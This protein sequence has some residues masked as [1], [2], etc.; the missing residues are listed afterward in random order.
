MYQFSTTQA[1]NVYKSILENPLHYAEVKAV[2]S[3]VEHD[4]SKIISG[5]ISGG[6][7]DTPGIGFCTSRELDIEFYPIGE[8]PRQAKIEIY[9]RITDGVN[10]SEWIPKG[11]YFVSR[12]EKNKVTGV[13]KITA[14]DSMLKAEDTFWRN[15]YKYWN[16]PASQQKVVD[17]IAYRMD[18]TVDIRTAYGST[19]V[20]FPVDEDG[21][22]TMREV[23]SSIAVSN[24]ANWV[25]T[26]KG[27]LRMIPY[28]D[29]PAET[30]L[31]VDER[32]YYITF[33]GDRIRV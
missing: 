5:S 11:I 15:E 10:T 14:F 29:I 1:E 22:M 21:D 13:L 3:G 17:E 31:L 19:P 7:Y 25:I 12:R 26:D 20:D 16:W 18:V 33:G 8:I 30:E 23:L 4:M 9:V 27:Q 24:A 28:Y 2:I 32:G 6:I